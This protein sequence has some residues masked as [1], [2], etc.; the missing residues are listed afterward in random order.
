[1]ATDSSGTLPNQA[2]LRA[3]LEDLIVR[4]L[5]GPIGGEDERI[6][7]TERVSDWYALGILA[8][9]N[10]VGTDPERDNSS[11]GTGGDED[12]S[13]D[14]PEERT[15]AKMLLPSSFGLSFALAPGTEQVL[16]TASW[17]RYE[18]MEDVEQLDDAGK[19]SRWWQRE[20]ISRNFVLPVANG[21]INPKSSDAC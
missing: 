10:T 7:G 12:S 14:E 11:E 16:V 15:A 5:L 9:R 20:P 8:P 13:E 18:K 3:E 21:A 2:D 17:G 6:P 19:P 1:M 4:D